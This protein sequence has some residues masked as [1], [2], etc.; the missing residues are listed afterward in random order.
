MHLT[1]LMKRHLLLFL[2]IL[3]AFA[4]QA[5][6]VYKTKTGSKYHI[7]SCSYLKSSFETTVA[8]AQAEGLTACSVC[9]PSAG[10]T[11]APSNAYQNDSRVQSTTS[12]SGSVQCAGTTKAGARCKRMTTNANGRCYQH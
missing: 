6:T 11:S 10:T 8:K 5:Q 4:S 7:Q 2:F 3:I 9:R 12:S 1:V